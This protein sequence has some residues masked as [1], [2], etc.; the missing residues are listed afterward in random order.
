MPLSS[1]ISSRCLPLMPDLS[2]RLDR[3][4][5]GLPTFDRRDFAIDLDRSLCFGQYPHHFGVALE[6]LHWMGKQLPQPAWVLQFGGRKVLNTSLEVF[7]VSVDAPEGNF[8]PEDETE[9]DLIG[10][11]FDLA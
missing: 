8:V 9:I 2:E 5:R 4:G 3:R 6:A 7:A 11:N 1:F 10:G